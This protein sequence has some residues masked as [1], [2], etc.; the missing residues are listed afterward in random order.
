[1]NNINDPQIKFASV[2]ML[3]T[4]KGTLRHAKILD[5]DKAWEVFEILE[6]SYFA[7]QDNHYKYNPH[8]EMANQILHTLMRQER[9]Q[10]RMSQEITKTQDD[11]QEIRDTIQINPKNWRSINNKVIHK[12]SLKNAEYKDKAKIYRELYAALDQRLGVHV[13]KR[14]NNKKNRMAIE[15]MS[16]SKIESTNILDIIEEDKKLIVGYIT[17]LKE[18]AIKNGIGVTENN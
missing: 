10:N 11:L 13:G 6:D 17:I 7:K 14:L 18:F 16:K 9:E 15:G 4:K 5:T 2:L 12:I 1:M 8:L 3:W